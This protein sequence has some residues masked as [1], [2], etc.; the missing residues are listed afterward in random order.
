MKR[1]IPTTLFGRIVCIL[2]G[3]LILAQ[4][5][6]EMVTVQERDRLLFQADQSQWFSRIASAV[7][8]LDSLPATQRPQVLPALAARRLSLEL[9]SAAS[10]TS[11]TLTAEDRTLS[12]LLGPQYAFHALS[13][14]VL[15]GVTFEVGLH[16]GQWVIVNY[17]A[18]GHFGWPLELLLSHG[19]LLIAAVV[20]TFI[21]ARFALRPLERFTQAAERLG[22]D[23]HSSPLPEQGTREVIR[24]ARAFNVMQAR[25]R[26]YVDERTRLLSAISHDLRT[27][28]TRLRLRAEFVRD[29]PAL[30]EALFR[31]L[32]IMEAMTTSVLDLFRGTSQGEPLRAVDINAL[33]ETIAADA[34]ELGVSVTVEGRAGA[35]YTA[36]SLA[37]R[38]C[39]EN[40]VGNAAKYGGSAHIAISD[41]EQ[42]LEIAVVDDGPGIP[43]EEL[44]AVFEPFYRIE[45]SRNRDTGG[46]GLGLTIARSIARAHGG[47]LTLRNRPAGGLEA[48]VR[49]P[50]RSLSGT[51]VELASQHRK[52][53]GE[54]PTNFD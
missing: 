50:R 29:D 10:G 11:T 19:L 25:I 26:Q 28:L 30:R 34:G 22:E 44:E 46:S 24:A 14:S 47:D 48:V 6:S 23:L 5:L 2:L 41:R 35:P 54:V 27:P 4:A 9:R 53:D 8:L 33:V 42:V 31:D 38:R 7:K 3:G 52:V 43:Q 45:P 1:W 17:E 36:R 49:L 40:L 16:D 32:T 18:P 51:R 13:S 15:G 20:L 37:L 21:A 12:K 39:L